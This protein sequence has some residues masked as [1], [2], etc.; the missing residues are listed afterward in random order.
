MVEAIDRVENL[1][2]KL[3]KIRRD[4]LESLQKSIKVVVIIQALSKLVGDKVNPQ[5]YTLS[6]VGDLVDETLRA[7]ILRACLKLIGMAVKS[8]RDIFSNIILG[9]IVNVELLQYFL[10]E[11]PFEDIPGP[12][13]HAHLEICRLA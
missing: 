3:L 12:A 10:S 4:V 5:K 7:N 2:E 8:V 13:R 11:L 6:S 9:R 1:L